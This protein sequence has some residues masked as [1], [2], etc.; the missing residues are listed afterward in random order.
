MLGV[1]WGVEL[2]EKE[3]PT[4]LPRYCG[5]TATLSGYVQYFAIARVDTVLWWCFVEWHCR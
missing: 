1:W 4:L 3:S 2:V 5:I